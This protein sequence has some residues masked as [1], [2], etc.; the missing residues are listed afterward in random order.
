[1]SLL[2]NA[3]SAWAYRRELRAVVAELESYS[4]RELQELGL[5]RADIPRVAALEAE[6]RIAKPIP[7]SDA[8]RWAGPGLLVQG[9]YQAC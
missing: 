6:R 9:R 5:T 1:M 3:L 2:D 7:G 4:A 8:R